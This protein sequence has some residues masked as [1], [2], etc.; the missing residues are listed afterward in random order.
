MLD[1]ERKDSE[2][3]QTIQ[4]RYIFNDTPQAQTATGDVVKIGLPEG[5]DAVVH[6]DV[7]FPYRQYWNV[8]HVQSGMTLCRYRRNRTEAVK[9]TRKRVAE[10]DPAELL[11]SLNQYAIEFTEYLNELWKESES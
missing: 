9:E 7:E 11:K 1:Q 3:K 2:V 8:T 6:R 10:K 4:L 5:H